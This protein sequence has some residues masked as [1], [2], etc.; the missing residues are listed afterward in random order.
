MNFQLPAFAI[1]CAMA[2]GREENNFLIVFDVR[3]LAATAGNQ[4]KEGDVYYRRNW[5]ALSPPHPGP[6]PL[7]R[8]QGGSQFAFARPANLPLPL[9]GGEGR[10][11]GVRP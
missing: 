9:R 2:D 1:C 11:E 3:N 6:R 7:E 10:G 8:G 5:T 4:K